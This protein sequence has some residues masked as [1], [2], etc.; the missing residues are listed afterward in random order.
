ML[1][2]VPIRAILLFAL[3]NRQVVSAHTAVLFINDLIP[4]HLAAC[5]AEPSR[6]ILPALRRVLDIIGCVVVD[7]A[8]RI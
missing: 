2:F 8:I 4:V 6:V 5:P 1:A 7:P 3:S